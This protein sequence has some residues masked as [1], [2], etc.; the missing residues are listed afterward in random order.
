MLENKASIDSKTI[1]ALMSGVINGNTAEVS[2][3]VG[4]CVE[5][6]YRKRIDKATKAV[7]ESIAANVKPVILG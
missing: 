1:K 7:F 3:I 2:R 4:A 5:S 6:E